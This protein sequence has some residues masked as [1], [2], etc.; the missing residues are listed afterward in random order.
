MDEQD[1]IHDWNK[2]GADAFEWD[3]LS[4]I[5]LNDET[6]RDGLQ[7]PSVV[8]PRIEDKIELLHLMD[9][10]GI[11]TANVGLPG[12]GPRAVDSAVALVREIVDSGLSISANC[13]A[14]TLV[15]DV[16]PIVEISQDAGI[17]IE[18]C[19]FIG[20]S[21]IR[22]FA[23]GWTLE[24]LLQISEKAV[25]FAVAEELPVMFV[26]EDTVRAR[27]DTLKALYGHA[28]EW[29]VGRLCVADTVGH[30]TP[31]GVTALIR[32]VIDEII[33]PSGA[34]V[35]VDWHGHR[36][37]GLGLPNAL[38]AVKAGATRIHGTALGVGERV[39]NVEMDLLL[40]NL[41]LLG[42]HDADLTRLPD[43]CNLA[44]DAC[45]IP[46]ASSYPVVGRDAFR[47]GSGVHASAIVKAKAKGHS[48]LA[49]RIYS[50]IPAAMVGRVQ[51]IE[52]GPFSG[53]SNVKAWLG[54][55]GYDPADPEACRIL[56]DAAKLADHTLTHDE[57]QSL[58]EGS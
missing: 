40:V 16:R 37:R 13:A 43:Y 36:D 28:I 18:A 51:E 5:Q 22:Q 9:E 39:G 45:Q 11:H 42:V 31:D 41:K 55:H 23:E 4:G 35:G 49:D 38:A 54:S 46:V 58:L 56:Y 1:L 8:D 52:V 15:A 26:T 33:K 7:N 12:A 27:P 17:P 21:P 57:I 6:L 3:S 20:S 10:L 29:G 50:G 47:T 53:L 32:F 25:T 24:D 30:A 48:W 2:E 44:A 14:R 34:A 19:T